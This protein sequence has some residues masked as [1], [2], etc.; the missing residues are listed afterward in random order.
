MK[1]KLTDDIEV[2]KVKIVRMNPTS[3]CQIEKNIFIFLGKIFCQG[4][5]VSPGQIVFQIH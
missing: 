5:N 1:T 3:F 4:I 2:I